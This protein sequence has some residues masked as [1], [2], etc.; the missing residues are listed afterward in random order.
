[1][2]IKT[3][4]FL[5]NDSLNQDSFSWVVDDSKW[6]DF[7]FSVRQGGDDV[8]IYL[9]TTDKKDFKGDLAKLNTL[10]EQLTEFR[11]TSVKAFPEALKNSVAND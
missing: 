5:S 11:D 1:M 8:S 10:I 7:Y 4:G 9:S 2:H 6:G 3:R